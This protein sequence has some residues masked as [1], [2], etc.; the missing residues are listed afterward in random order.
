[1][2]GVSTDCTGN[3]SPQGFLNGPVSFPLATTIVTCSASD[4][5]GNTGT[6]TFT[7]TVTYTLPA[8]T[9]PPTITLPSDLVNGFIISR[10]DIA[11][12]TD[13]V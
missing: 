6:G 4:A 7:V 2:Q 11:T 9:T 8:D 5:A 1:M 13:G 3:F 10:S 12:M